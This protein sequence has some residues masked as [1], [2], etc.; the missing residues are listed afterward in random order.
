M[1]ITA[2]SDTH[3][4]LD[5]RDICPKKTDILICA[6]D[7]MGHSNNFSQFELAVKQMSIIKAEH[8][9]FVSGN[10]DGVTD[11]NGDLSMMYPQAI[12]LL[13]KY[14]IT[15]LHNKIVTIDGIKFG[16]SSIQPFF[17]NWYH[18]EKCNEIRYKS[19]MKLKS[20]DVLITHCPPHNILDQNQFGEHCGDVM[21][22]KALKSF[23]NLR[24][25]IFGHIH[26]NNTKENLIKKNNVT[27][28]NC[29]ICDELYRP[30][31]SVVRINYVD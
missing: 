3:S 7:V 28:I 31:N 30:I 11:K 10:H 4:L 2:F 26:I 29:S 16:G 23:T 27:Y 13:K 12:S 1:K 21:L 24:Y 18:N 20:V 17:N 5:I 15:F 6:G 19:F 9:L 25:S 22:S 14:N 8:K